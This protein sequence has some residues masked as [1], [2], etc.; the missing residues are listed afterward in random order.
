M[1]QLQISQLAVG[2]TY[3]VCCGWAKLNKACCRGEISA[4][5]ACCGWEGSQLSQPL[6][7]GQTSAFST[8]CE[9]Y[10][11][12]LTQAYLA[13]R[14]CRYLSL[15]SLLCSACCGQANLN[16]LSLLLV[17]RFQLTQLAISQQNSAC[18]ACC[19]RTEF[20]VGGQTSQPAPLVGEQ[21]SAYSALCGWTHLVFVWE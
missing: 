16:L 15:L 20:V 4:D 7:G 2:S 1:G 3:R 19:R 17:G 21:V 9:V 8:C 10:K 13:C 11:S 14:R 18:S 6:V 12:E 5:S